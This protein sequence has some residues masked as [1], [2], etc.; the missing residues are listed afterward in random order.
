M[1]VRTPVLVL[2]LPAFLLAA[3]SG[4][5]AE[6]GPHAYVGVSKC[7][8]CHNKK[9]KGAQYSVWRESAHARAWETLA[10]PAALA[11]AEELDLGVPPQESPR[12]LECHVT[13]SGD[14]GELT[15]KLKEKNGVGCESCH[16]AGG[17]YHR[18]DEMTAIFRGALMPET[19]GLVFPNETVCLRCHNDRSPTF[20]GFD[21]DEA[22][23]RIAHPH[24]AAL[25][26]ARRAGALEDERSLEGERP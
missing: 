10:S 4:R 11:I 26:E 7:K 21:F 17:A 25:E 5:A 15:G 23:A 1:A 9:A 3:P 12:C 24:P 22:V 19:V 13:G 16:G 20:A 6:K 2:L 14:P 18:K 8:S